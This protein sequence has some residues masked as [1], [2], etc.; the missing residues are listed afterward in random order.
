MCGIIGCITSD[1]CAAKSVYEGLLRLEYRGYDSVGIS[2]LGGGKIV[3]VKKSGRVSGL[4]EYVGGLKGNVAAGHTRWATHGAPSDVNAH[5]HCEGRFSVV[6]NG[7]IENYAELRDELI[8]RGYEFR[9]ETDSE[10]A[11]KLIADNF[12]GDVLAAVAA[13]AVRL[14]GSF[15]LVV[16]CEGFEGFVAV[17][18]RSSLVVGVCEEGIF[19]ASDVPALPE[20][21]DEITVMEDGDIAVITRSGAQYFDF[22]LNPVTR[23]ARR[24]ERDGFTADKGGYPH[25][26]LKE[27]N[28][29]ARAV[30]DTVE[31][32][33]R[34]VDLGRLRSL[35][36]GADEIILTGCGTAYNSGL[37]A[38]RFFGEN[39]ARVRVEIASELRYYPPKMSKNTLVIAISQSG[40]TADTVGAVSLFRQTGAQVI[41]VTNCGYS[42][43]TRLANIVVPVCAGA[44]ICV[45]ATKSYFGQ[46]AALY[47][48][49]N[50]CADV[51]FAKSQLRSVALQFSSVLSQTAECE[52]FAGMCA[53]SRA[54]FFMGR[55]ADYDVAVE[56]SLKLK[57]VSYIFSDAYPAGEL[58]HGTLALIDGDTLGI[59][60]ICQERTAEKCISA[61]HEVLCRGGKAAIITDMEAEDDSL[62]GVPVWRIPRVGKMSVFLSAFALQLVAYRTAV[63]IGRDPDK[64]RNLAKSVTVE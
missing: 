50:V 42:A 26:M 60:V 47:L 6:H 63:K 31:G 1:D 2:A 35:V 5:P 55:G 48:T 22:C 10:V 49:A 37:I 39:S 36:S 3:T 40:E 43:I 57:E 46:L 9:S 34:S 59:F 29:S 53:A 62:D 41:A 17:R 54:V 15:A 27:L 28:Q 8:S 13:A 7:I 38:A 51:A 20:S 45:A 32:F 61:V 52:C 33:F 58:K 16:L 11:V 44:E 12:R 24:V 30:E 25:F 21:A 14:R 56:A 4:A 23:R 64:P 19:A 18:N